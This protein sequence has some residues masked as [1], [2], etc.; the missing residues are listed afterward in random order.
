[1]NAAIHRYYLTKPILVREGCI[2]EAEGRR[3]VDQSARDVFNMLE[4]SAPRHSDYQRRASP[5]QRSLKSNEREFIELVRT[6]LTDYT[7]QEI[8]L[9]LLRRMRRTQW[10]AFIKSMYFLITIRREAR[11]QRLSDSLAACVSALKERDA[12][13]QER[14]LLLKYRDKLLS[15]LDTANKLIDSLIEARDRLAANI[16]KVFVE[17][18]SDTGGVNAHANTESLLSK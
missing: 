11:N 6:S 18:H 16:N 7:T 9:E 5:S 8:F 3:L 12:L 17:K 1:M 15:Q 2:D 10:P 4:T 14:E 13:V